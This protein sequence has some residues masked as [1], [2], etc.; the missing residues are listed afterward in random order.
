MNRHFCPAY[1]GPHVCDWNCGAG[2]TSVALAEL[3][4]ADPAPCPA[5]EIGEFATI[6]HV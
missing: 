3:A 4:Y 6:C 1:I 2:L 5:P